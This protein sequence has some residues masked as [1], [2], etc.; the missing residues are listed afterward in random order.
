VQQVVAIEG[1]APPI[2]LTD[3]LLAW[4]DSERGRFA[5]WL[6]VFMASGVLLYFA[7]TSEPP[8]W[9][10]AAV[11]VS[12]L[13]SLI[14][15]WRIW[16][17]RM[18]AS[19]LL[20]VGLGLLSA[21]W[22][23]WRAKP[24][25]E[26]PRKAVVLT[27][28]VRAVDV[29]PD[30][31]RL[32]LDGVRLGDSEPLER[33]IR[34]RMKR[35]DDQAVVAG[36]VVQIRALVRP[37][38]PPAYPGGWDMQRSSFFDGLGGGGTALNPVVVLE[39]HPPSGFTAVVQAWRDA[40]GR[41]VMAVVPGSPGAI[42]ATFLTGSTYA[43]PAADRAAFR[44]SGLAHLL[45]VA[46]LHIGIVMGLVFGLTRLLLA[47]WE[48]SALHWP[49]K[50][51]AAVTSLTAGC[52]YMFM[53]GTHVP[54]MRS[55]AMACLV[56]L[57]LVVGRRAI[58]LRGWALAALALMLIAPQEVVG[59]SFQMSFA[60][61]LALISGYE[62][63]RPVL[64]RLYG[65]QWWRRTASHV[66]ALVLTSLLAGS[67]SAPFGAFHF[68]HMQLYFIAA[69]VI[70]VPL[71]AMWVMPAGLIGLAL[72]PFGLEWLALVPMGWGVQAILWIGREVSSWP[73]ATV[74][75]PPMPGWGLAVFSLGLAW[76]C[77]WRTRWRMA[78][79]VPI[80]VGLLSPVVT[81]LPDVLVSDDAR[82][83]AIRAD[84]GYWVQKHHGGSKFTLEEWEGHFAS[85]KMLPI[86]EGTPSVCDTESCRLGPILLMRDTARPAICRGSS[87]LVSAEPMRGEC[88]SRVELLD[89]FTVWR[90]AAYAG[91]IEGDRVRLV[92]DR[93]FRGD[94]PWVP[95]IPTPR[96]V[97]PNL[98]MAATETLPDLPEATS[99]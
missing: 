4:A 71:T 64:T 84:G 46:G 82:L 63:L 81:P 18:A 14:L 32:V 25:V 5:P 87:L 91:W 57:G 26:L 6:S 67:A 60:A 94:R 51:I 52:V 92:S 9:A 69:N 98:P 24:M 39:H 15:A 2:R 47:C 89:R 23:A 45:A 13:A 31:R 59:V 88:P 70:A 19:A 11:S 40:I 74:A 7:I 97:A 3:R 61:V 37:P 43:I 93:S 76:L 56:T 55:F 42:S 85:G 65:H 80:M 16:G 77:L 10:G 48:R 95:G 36:D 12:G 99:E 75:V 35:G 90:N 54:V 1:Y 34:V 30:G 44:D 79:L 33:R 49:T 83:I 38:S 68:G 78:G 27:A 20:A 66:L 62:A 28:T 86:A 29:L 58:S 21:Q 53:A 72:M 8:L 73:S 41:R 50:P 96:R 22:A 17:G